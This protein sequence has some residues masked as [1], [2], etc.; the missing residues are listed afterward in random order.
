MTASPRRPLA[1]AVSA[2]ACGAGSRVHLPAAGG[3]RDRSGRCSGCI[4]TDER[5]HDAGLFI[6]NKWTS[7]RSSDLIFR[8]SHAGALPPPYNLYKRVFNLFQSHSVH[9][10]PNK[11]NCSHRMSPS[12]A[13]SCKLKGAECMHV[14]LSS[15]APVTQYAMGPC[16]P[17]TSTS[18]HTTENFP[19][20]ALLFLFVLLPVSD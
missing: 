18:T 20:V 10:K 9:F 13:I 15:E 11:A 5:R 12:D 3:S 16:A 17:L 8:P 4:D 2:A 7:G 14:F 19:L 6:L 1:Q